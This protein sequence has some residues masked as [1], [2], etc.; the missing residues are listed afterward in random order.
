MSNAPRDK[1]R[2]RFWGDDDSQTNILHID[3]DSFFAQVEIRQDPSL[4][5][6]AVIVGG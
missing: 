1:R 3:M 6:K 5:G 2:K 4:V